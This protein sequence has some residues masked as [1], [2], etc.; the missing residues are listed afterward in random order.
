MELIIVMGVRV[1]GNQFEQFKNTKKRNEWKKSEKKILTE[2]P[3]LHGWRGGEG[4]GLYFP[5]S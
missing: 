4:G 3:L 5:C 1:F 2:K